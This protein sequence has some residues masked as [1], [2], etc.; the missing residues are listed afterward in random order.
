MIR[1][2]IEIVYATLGALVK[3]YPELSS[4]PRMVYDYTPERIMGDA[5]PAVG[6]QRLSNP[7]HKLIDKHED[8]ARSKHN[9]VEYVWREAGRFDVACQVALFVSASETIVN[10]TTFIR[11][12]VHHV[13]KRIIDEVRFATVGDPVDGEMLRLRSLAEPF[14]QE[15][16]LLVSAKLT[17]H[18]EGK[19]LS[20]QKTIHE[21]Q[22]KKPLIVVSVTL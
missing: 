7:Q 19:Y 22:S 18:A 15:A 9:G 3:S 4:P 8:Y 12:W 17:L 14:Q 13:E 11:G 21:E 1:N 10:P 5:F 16:K 20:G 6:I 2:E